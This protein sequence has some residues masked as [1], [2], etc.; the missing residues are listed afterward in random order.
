MNI[1]ITFLA[2]SF[3]SQGTEGVFLFSATDATAKRTGAMHWLINEFIKSRSGEE[4]ILDF[5]GSNLPGLARFYKRVGSKETV[6]L[7]VRKNNLP[8]IIKWIKEIKL[9]AGNRQ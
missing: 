1:L 9:A 6:Y 4:M 2:P 5:E 7:Q 8:K 3:V